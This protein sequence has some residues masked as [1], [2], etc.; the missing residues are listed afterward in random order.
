MATASAYYDATDLTRVVPT[1]HL[2]GRPL[3]DDLADRI[4]RVVVDTH[5]LR[6]DM[7]EI[8]FLDRDLTVAA[9][10]ELAIGTQLSI[11]S[12]TA[13][14]TAQTELITGEITAI[15]GNYGRANRT[16]VRGYTK[17]HRLQRARRSRS[18][19][20]RK[21]SE[22]ARDI[23]KEYGLPVGTVHQ[24][25]T[26]HVH[27]GQVNQTDWEFLRARADEIGYDV[28]MVDGKFCFTR[29]VDVRRAGSPVKLAFPEQLRL[30]QPRITAGNL[31][32]DT[33]VRTWDSATRRAGST[34]AATRTGAVNVD[35]ADVRTLTGGFAPRPGRMAKPDPT[36][37]ELGP[38]PKQNAFAVTTT[39]V[40]AG[41]AAGEVA[42]GTA[43]RL[44][45]T[46]AAATG[47]TVGDPRLRAGTVLAISGLGSTFGGRWLVSR[48]VH[49]YDLTGY[50]TS[51]EVSGRHERSI[52]GLA[53]TGVRPATPASIPGVVCGVVS[54]IGDPDRRGRVRLVLPWLSP[55]FVTDWAPVALA[56]AGPHSAA[57]LL[58]EVGDEV[59]VAFEFGD[60]RRP[61]VLGGLLHDKSTH[62]LGGQ[63]VRTS[64]STASVI[65]R[66]IVSP[67]GNRL[68]F[69]DE[70]TPGSKP[71]PTKSE[72]VLGTGR[73]DVAVVIDQIAGSVTVT[74]KAGGTIDVKAGSGGTVNIG[75]GAQLNLSATG[76]IKIDSKGPVEIKGNP[77][78]LN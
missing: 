30:F 24:T 46:V 49:T 36:L 17:D 65:W 42:A 31:V 45:S 62:D 58:P 52:L 67:N 50:V 51:F 76:S 53:G 4:A 3:A 69:H 70:R 73:G 43:E 9:T 19:P 15:E 13:T 77:I 8:T 37:G 20:N 66:G 68:A 34:T 38:L 22:L 78:K 63:P 28:G 56:G 16:V 14:D 10:P 54:D 55:V 6:P 47:E 61:Y 12:P 72:I 40:P 33:E 11:S 18:F 32:P 44:A 59:L 64:G 35:M 75:G 26:T 21:D 29:A 5:Q 25:R 1:V 39:A 74:C 2:G 7:F 23:A 48:A 57:L 41:A 71:T 60:P 27:I